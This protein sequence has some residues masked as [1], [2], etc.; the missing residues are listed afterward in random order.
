[1]KRFAFLVNPIAGMGGA[2]GLKGT[3]GEEVL[4][5]AVKRGA[6]KV[7]HSRAVEALS[8]LKGSGLEVLTCGGEMGEDA[9]R[10]A[11]I[12][13]YGV[14]HAPEGETHAEDTKEAC[15]RFLQEGAA[16]LLFCGGDGTARDIFEV[17]GEKVPVLGIPA[18]VKMHSG[19]FAVGTEAASKLVHDFM[20]GRAEVVETEVMDIDEE[21]YRKGRL[22]V[23]LFGCA[24][25]PSEPALVQ[26][27]KAVFYSQSEEHAK[28][29]IATFASEFMWDDSLYIMGAGSTLAKVAEALGLEKTLLGVD[30]VKNR[31]LVAKDVSEHEI[32]AALEGE[33]KVKIMISPIGAQG[34]VF[35]RGNQQIS[36]RVIEKVGKENII[37]L[38]TPHKLEKTPTLLVDTGDRGLD[39]ELSGKMQ[40]VTGYRMAQRREVRSV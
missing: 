21:E 2:V 17:V 36:A 3:D 10:E 24:K 4:R 25:T 11:G 15:R 22:D 37:I 30:V 32:L 23:K 5:E 18:G 14:V 39:R 19:V 34:F 29:A 1:M 13:G 27:S 33:K 35:G 16:L 28:E 9:L 40:V 12:E 31:K 6:R 8:P 7:A 38:A 26:G 20:E